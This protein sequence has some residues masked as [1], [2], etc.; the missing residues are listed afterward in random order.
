MA[1][2]TTS[3]RCVKVAQPQPC[4]PGW[5]V[6]TFTTTRRMPLGAVRID[7]DVLDADRRQATRRWRHGRRL[8]QHLAPCHQPGPCQ[9]RARRRQRAQHVTSLH[10][11]S[12]WRACCV[13]VDRGVKPHVRR[14]HHR[15]FVTQ[16]TGRPLAGGPAGRL[17]VGAGGATL[18]R[19]TRPP[20]VSSAR[21]SG[22][23]FADGHHPRPGSA[24]PLLRGP[25]GAVGLGRHRARA[26]S[27]TS[28]G[29]SRRLYRNVCDETGAVR[30]HLNV[31][32]NAD[33][34]R[35]RDGLDTTLAPGDVVTILPA[36]S[37]G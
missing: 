9:H 18:R 2:C 17:H 10:A 24:A 11:V 16:A 36:V 1:V 6:M 28:S 7:L 20:W 25:G 19:D 29:A 31:F 5:S 22:E 26:C 14:A 23:Q 30:R 15:A 8:R 4:R 37:G 32:V 12:S 13:V 35:D 27:R 34:M 21:A 3:A 33:H